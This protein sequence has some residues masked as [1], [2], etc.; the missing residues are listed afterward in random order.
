MPSEIPMPS[1]SLTTIPMTV[2]ERSKLSQLE[3]HILLFAEELPFEISC[4]RLSIGPVIRALSPEIESGDSDPLEKIYAYMELVRELDRDKLF[5]MVNMR[6]Y[7]SDEA[8]E[9]FAETV[10]LHDLKVF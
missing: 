2:P 9:S 4:Q 3:A 10:C 5:I 8:M 6:T 1:L 7:F